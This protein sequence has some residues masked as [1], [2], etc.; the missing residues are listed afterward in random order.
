MKVKKID[1][2]GRTLEEVFATITPTKIACCNWK[3]EYPYAPDVEFR[4]FHTGSHLHVRF[5]VTEQY[6]VARIA[7]DNGDVWTDSCCEFFFSLDGEKYYNVETNCIGRM[8]IGHYT[9]P[10][11][12]LIRA[13]EEILSQVQRITSLGTEP[14]GEREGD[15]SWSLMLSLPT[16]VFHQDD[17]K[18]WDGLR[19]KAN[20][21]KC[22]D[23][24]TKPHYLSWLPIDTPQPNFH[25]PP[26]F[27]DLEME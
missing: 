12:N 8:L 23:G 3:E 2:T 22:G 21:Y 13:G 27:G 17:I 16:A 6:T 26:Y 10:K 14:F 11:E 19:L 18:S 7:E 20:L 4:L 15:N 5:D 24:L 25:C 9:A 1:M